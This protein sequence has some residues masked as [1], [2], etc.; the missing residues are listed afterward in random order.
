MKKILLIL[1]TYALTLPTYAAVVIDKQPNPGTGFGGLNSNVGLDFEREADDFSLSAPTQVNTVSW[2]GWFRDTSIL[3]G[4][5]D[6]LFFNDV[7]LPSNPAFY[8]T[9]VSNVTGASTGMTT[10]SGI[11]IFKWTATIPAASFSASGDYWLSV[12]G[13]ADLLDLDT[14]WIWAFGEAITGEGDI[15][16]QD[17]AGPCGTSPPTCE[18]PDVWQSSSITDAFAF[19]L[20]NVPIP[21]ALWLFASGFLGLI[22]MAR[23]KVLS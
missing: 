20:S 10:S 4:D 2:Y 12:Q 23:R 6:I 8:T 15:A 13:Y 16:W 9:T 19:T 7:G 18:E 3:T 1:I 21:P 22:G 5:F 14:Y 17:D 11:P